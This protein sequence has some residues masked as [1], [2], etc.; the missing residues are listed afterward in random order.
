MVDVKFKF[1]MLFKNK[2]NNFYQISAVKDYET[3]IK[4][5]GEKSLVRARKRTQDLRK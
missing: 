3:E 4:G 5:Q 2:G 1:I